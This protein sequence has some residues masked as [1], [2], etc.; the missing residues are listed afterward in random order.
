MDAGCVESAKHW[1]E[2]HETASK[3]LSQSESRPESRVAGPQRFETR[4]SALSEIKKDRQTFKVGT[5]TIIL[6]NP[7]LI[8]TL[9]PFQ[10]LAISD[11]LMVSR[12]NCSA[13]H[14]KTVRYCCVDAVCK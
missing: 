8:W 10:T 6:L 3:L 7:G 12:R 11:C 5:M 2:A 1:V 13:R 14:S 9:T 4:M